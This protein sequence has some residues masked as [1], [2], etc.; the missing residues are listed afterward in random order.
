VIPNI[1]HGI[2]DYSIGRGTAVR[3]GTI[4]FV[5]LPGQTPI[6]DEEYTESSNI[7]ITTRL[8]SSNGS[9]NLVL[10][11]SNS[12]LDATLNFDVKTLH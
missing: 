6:H 3:S 11:L 9:T 5:V 8:A 4:K 7:G 1:A 10:T 12:G 2:I